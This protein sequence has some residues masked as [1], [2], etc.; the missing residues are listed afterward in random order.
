MHTE[1]SLGM[2]EYMSMLASFLLLLW[3]NLHRLLSKK[4][5]FI[6]A[7][8]SGNSRPKQYCLGSGKASLVCTTSWCEC[9]RVC[10]CMASLPL[11]IKP[12]GSKGLI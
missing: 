11:I 5:K 4:N 7:H 2:Y 1:M 10:L 3:N 12:P 6:L 8:S 9:V